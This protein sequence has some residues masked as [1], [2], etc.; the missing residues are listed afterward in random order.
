MSLL[1]KSRLDMQCRAEWSNILDCTNVEQVI[2]GI[3]KEYSIK[4]SSGLRLSNLYNNTVYL[5]PHPVFILNAFKYV[6]PYDLRFVLITDSIPTDRDYRGIPLDKEVAYS[7]E[8]SSPDVIID[9][10]KYNGLSE[11][12]DIYRWMKQG[13]LPLC[14]N[15]TRDSR[16]IGLHKEI[17][18]DF[19]ERF[20]KELDNL[21]ESKLPVITFGLDAAW[22]TRNYNAPV[23]QMPKPVKHP[24]GEYDKFVKHKGFDTLNKYLIDQGDSFIF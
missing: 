18:S 6:D 21:Y 12:F 7:H 9:N 10:L 11:S 4:T 24:N 5:I 17:W 20:L 13:C 1:D 22:L 15:L 2:K 23:I 8:D 14:V 19:I 16:N 3:V